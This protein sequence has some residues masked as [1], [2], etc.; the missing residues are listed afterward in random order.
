MCITQAMLKAKLRKVP[1]QE[2]IP[3]R[4]RKDEIITFSESNM[5][6]LILPQLDVLVFSLVVANHEIIQ[7]YIDNAVVVNILF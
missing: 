6:P 5:V 7:V 1:P 2:P 4:S 3:K